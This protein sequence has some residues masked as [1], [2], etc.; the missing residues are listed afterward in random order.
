[1]IHTQFEGGLK[2]GVNNPQNDT[3]NELE[4]VIGVYRGAKH[5]EFH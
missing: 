4:K 3:D 2:V 5:K 1:M